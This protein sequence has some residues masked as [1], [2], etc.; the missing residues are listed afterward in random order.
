MRVF[1][2]LL[3]LPGVAEPQVLVL[4][5][6]DGTLPILQA[7]V[8]GIVDCV[9]LQPDFDMWVHDEGRL[10]GLQP[11]RFNLCGNIV[12]TRSDDEGNTRSLDDLD[13]HRLKRLLS[14]VRV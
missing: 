7:L 1:R 4:V 8:G 2:C 6:E 11:N 10:L 5:E 12:V 3:L 9:S 13:V 14:H